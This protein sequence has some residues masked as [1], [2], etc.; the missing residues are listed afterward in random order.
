MYG[1]KEMLEVKRWV[2]S[3]VLQS[4]H[5]ATFKQSFYFALIYYFKLWIITKDS[6]ERHDD[7]M[8]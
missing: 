5:W 3:S 1:T 7:A 4:V 6:L 2:L 8:N